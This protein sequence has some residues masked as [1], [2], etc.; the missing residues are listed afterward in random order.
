[1]KLG[2]RSSGFILEQTTFY[3]GVLAQVGI[4]VALKPHFVYLS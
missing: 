2:L 3:D 4:G 1:M